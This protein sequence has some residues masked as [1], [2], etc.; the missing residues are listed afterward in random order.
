MLRYSW[1]VS[2]RCPRSNR[3]GWMKW[4]ELSHRYVEPHISFSVVLL[5]DGNVAEWCRAGH[6]SL[7]CH[8]STVQQRLFAGSSLFVPY[9]QQLQSQFRWVWTPRL[10]YDLV[11]KVS[12][13]L[14]PV[15]RHSLSSSGLQLSTRKKCHQIS[16]GL[17]HRGWKERFPSKIDICLPCSNVTL[18]HP[19]IPLNA[20]PDFAHPARVKTAVTSLASVGACFQ[21]P[22]VNWSAS[23]SP[24][25]RLGFGKIDSC[26]PLN[27]R[28]THT[29]TC[30]ECHF[31]W[32]ERMFSISVWPWQ[33]LKLTLLRAL[34]SFWAPGC[35]HPSFT[36]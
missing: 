31:C 25:M 5:L 18:S 1:K 4:F 29:H 27:G 24:L 17:P 20:G 15:C 3:V 2:W 19:V 26:P 21:F 12:I 14:W 13:A 34:L 9:V 36:V 6:Y 35:H 30:S 33:H 10:N 7:G 23:L 28:C 16:C 8:W 22:P 32:Q 11:T